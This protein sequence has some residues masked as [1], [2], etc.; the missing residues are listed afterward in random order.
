MA[1]LIEIDIRSFI[2]GIDKRTF[3]FKVI[4]MK[5]FSDCSGLCCVCALC[6]G[7]LAGHGD[8][9]F[10]LASKEQIIENLDCGRYTTWRDEMIKTLREK[11]KYDYNERI[12]VDD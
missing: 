9:Y 3:L 2:V 10:I 1:I 12:Y 4:D 11:Y 7:C 8:D 6:K 5:F